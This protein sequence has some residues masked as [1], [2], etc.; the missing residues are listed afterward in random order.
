MENFSWWK[1][2]SILN[3]LETNKLFSVMHLVKANNRIRVLRSLHGWYHLCKQTV[4]EV[5]NV[6]FLPKGHK[7][8]NKP[9]KGRLK[10]SLYLN[11][12]SLSAVLVAVLVCAGGMREDM[13]ATSRG[14]WISVGSCSTVPSASVPGGQLRF[15]G[16]KPRHA[17]VLCCYH[18]GPFFWTSN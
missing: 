16:S 9:M 5:L 10:S 7:Q 18:Q 2:T 3:E 4:T 6:S 8:E 13:W 17:H 14:T 12:Y 1:S 15:C 11:K